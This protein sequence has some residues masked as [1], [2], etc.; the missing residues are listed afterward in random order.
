MTILT[1]LTSPE[2]YLTKFVN[3][4]NYKNLSVVIL[5]YRATHFLIGIDDDNGLTWE[6][7]LFI[8]IICYYSSIL[9]KNK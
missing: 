1:K 7:L 5:C 4:R 8:F 2:G 9:P 3:V 6:K